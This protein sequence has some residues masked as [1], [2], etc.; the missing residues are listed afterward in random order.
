MLQTKE[1]EAKKIILFASFKKQTN[2][3]TNHQTTRAGVHLSWAAAF[4][5]G[6]W[7]FSTLSTDPG[8]LCYTHGR[9]PVHCPTPLLHTWKQLTPSDRSLYPS[10]ERGFVET[11]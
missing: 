8:P 4:F 7:L 11:P 1:T 6:I 5:V 3:Q 9:Q 2:K 10:S